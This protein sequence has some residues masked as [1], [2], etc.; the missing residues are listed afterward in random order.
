MEFGLNDEDEA[1][2]AE[3][4]DFLRR[5]HP[6][7]EPR[8][9]RLA[10][11]KQ[12]AATLADEG[13]AAP[14]WPKEW[15]GM[16]LPLTQ[17]LVYH[18]EMTLAGVPAHPSGTSFIVAPTII[19]HGTTAQRQ[20]FLKP[21]IRADELWCQGFSEPGAGSDLQSLRTRAVRDGDDYVV[22]G[23]KVWT[24]GA[25]VADWMFALVRTG[26]EESRQHGITYLL[27]SMHSPGVTVRPLRDMT[28]DAGFAEVFFE[29][30]RVP[31]D[32]RVGEENHGWAITRT[33]LGH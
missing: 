5:H 15:G 32:Q 28:G 25:P 1:F 9:D 8:D 23:Q 19:R 27:L 24:S 20:R 22:N 31:V 21:L 2:R 12:G 17:Q 3:L 33:S 13:W 10:F 4:Q 26:S 29:D 16:D 18:E 7:R 30:V 6:G 11:R 14:A